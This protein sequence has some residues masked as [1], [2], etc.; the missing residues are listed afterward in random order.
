MFDP[1]KSH[2]LLI[3]TDILR[4]ISLKLHCNELKGYLKKSMLAFLDWKGRKSSGFERNRA[5]GTVVIKGVGRDLG[6]CSIG[7]LRNLQY[8]CRIV[9]CR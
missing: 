8:G 6:M 1:Y 3:Y 9:L 4:W 2:L 5:G 7:P